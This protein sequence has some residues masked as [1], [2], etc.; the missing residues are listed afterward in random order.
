M[1]RRNPSTL[2]VWGDQG[3]RVVASESYWR[4]PLKWDR[5]AAAAGERRRVFCA[6]LADVFE[7]RPELDAPRQRLFDLIL[8]TQHLD[9]LLL[10]KRPLVMRDWLAAAGG[11][12]ADAGR[13][14]HAWGGG[15]PNVWL[16]VSVEDQARA[17][18]RIPILLSIPAAV[19]WISAEPLLGPLDLEDYLHQYHGRPAKRWPHGPLKWVIVGGESGAAARPMHPDW[20]RSIR[21]Q[22]RTTG[23]A[24]FFKQWGH[25]QPGYR[26]GAGQV[27]VARADGAIGH[28]A[29]EIAAAAGELVGGRA[30]LLSPVGKKAAGALLDGREH[31]E[32]PSSALYVRD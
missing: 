32:Y 29:E 7:D 8:Q 21:D 6:S 23:R 17:R 1:S 25:Y 27:C 14:A 15:W 4:Q 12:L 24:F 19:H 5:E 9:W 26:E 22:C 2:G 28:G 3:T 31:K 30:S 11:D 20:A 13:S 10:T 18:E 16:G